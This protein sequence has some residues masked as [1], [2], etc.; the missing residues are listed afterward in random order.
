MAYDGGPG[1]G[2]LREAVQQDDG[3]AARG[4]AVPDVEDQTVARE[5]VHPATVPRGSG[6]RQSVPGW[7]AALG[8]ASRGDQLG[9]PF[10]VLAHHQC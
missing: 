4:A 8:A 9:S 10:R 5:A 2:V 3:V 6:R 7:V 1:G